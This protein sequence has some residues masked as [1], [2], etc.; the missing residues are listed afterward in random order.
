MEENFR[1]RRIQQFMDTIE[2]HSLD[3]SAMMQADRVSLAA[4][5][6]KP[7]LAK[8]APTNDRRR[9]ALRLIAP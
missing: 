7:I 5:A 6:M 4:L 9:E 8:I 1:A 3:T 2:K